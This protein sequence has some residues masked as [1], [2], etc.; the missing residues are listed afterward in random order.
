MIP[1]RMSRPV[2]VLLLT[3]ASIAVVALST[4][5]G[6]E[7]ITVPKSDPTHA[8]A[9]LFSQRC[10]G[11]H[12]L[13]FAATHGSAPNSRSPEFNNG[14]NFNLR[15]ERPVTRVLYAIEDG[16]FEGSIMP[17]DIVVGQD[18]VNVAQFVAK[19]AGRQALKIPGQPVC[20][21]N[22]VGTIPPPPVAAAPPSTPPSTPA[23]AKPAG[24]KP[25]AKP[26][27]AAAG[28]AKKTTPTTGSAKPKSKA[29]GGNA[30]KQ[31]AHP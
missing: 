26:Q 23:S 21:A 30:K 10:S 25:G 9:V 5:C 16:G 6:T 4:A 8:G 14:P 19:Y 24:H 31:T 18:A 13:S 22:P 12:T 7:R 2:R 3:G 1:P 15:C 29:A 17:Q 11:C 20:D 28:H 27:Q